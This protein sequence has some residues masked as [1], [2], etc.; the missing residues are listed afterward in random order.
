[1]ESNDPVFLTAFIGRSFLP[2]DEAPWLE[3]RKILESLRP[4][5]FLFH[6]AYEAQPRRISEKVQRGIEQHD[7]YIGILTRRFPISDKKRS[8]FNFL[9]PSDVPRWGTTA[10][11]V[12]ECGFALGRGKK[13][14]LLLEEGVDFPRSDLDADKERIIFNRKSVIQCSGHL[15]AMVANLI[16]ER[17]PALPAAAL[18]VVQTSAPP[19]ENP[20]SDESTAAAEAPTFAKVT[21]LLDANELDKADEQFKE[22]EAAFEASG[23]FPKGWL[24]RYYLREKAVRGDKA[25]LRALV[26]LTEKEPEDQVAWLQLSQYYSALD[27][28]KQAAEVLIKGSTKVGPK[29]RS[30]LIR[31]AAKEESLNSRFDESY[32]LLRQALQESKSTPDQKQTFQTLA[33]FA[34]EQKNRD[35][36]AAALERALEL[37]PSDRAVRF[38]LA[39]LYGETNKNGLE[40]YHYRLRLAQG[41]EPSSLNNLGVSLNQIECPSASIDCLMQAVSNNPLAKANLGHAYIDRGFLTEGERLAREASA[42]AVENGDNTTLMRATGAIDRIA[43]ERS[44]E[45]EREAKVVAEAKRDAGFRARYGQA[46]MDVP[47]ESFNGVFNSPRGHMWLGQE[48]RNLHGEIAEGS[49]GATAPSVVRKSLVVGKVQ[50]RAGTFVTHAAEAAS[51]GTSLLMSPKSSKGFFIIS[52]DRQSVEFAE[53]EEKNLNIYSADRSD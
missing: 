14:L 41:A 13:V 15:T 3:I 33:D 42:T 21:E 26:E 44:T 9:R 11:V 7:L 40:I 35:L 28:H 17:L 49:V 22:V 34:K 16:K 8:L 6:D 25:S 10:W 38:R 52:V 4:L 47:V 46:F 36:E 29:S 2:P 37:D 48:G 31:A 30:R 53:E 24:H 43:E 1:M 51:S 45:K 39:F 18:P 50:G 32:D 20:P 5:G 12:Q 27:L 23:D 19:V